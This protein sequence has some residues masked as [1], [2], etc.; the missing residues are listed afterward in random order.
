[1]NQD[2][3]GRPRLAA[4]VD[5]RVAGLWQAFMLRGV[6]A[7]V[8]GLCALI[9]PSVSLAILL[10]LVGLYCVADGAAGVLGAWRAAERGAN[11][12]QAL[13]GIVAGA[14]L[15]FW[16]GG[17]LRTLLV[18]F[19]AWALLT[20]LSQIVAARQAEVE[21]SDRRLMTSIGG[22]AAALGPD[23]DRLARHRGGDRLGDR[24]CGAAAGGAPDLPRAAPQAPA[25]PRG[26]LRP[27]APLARTRAAPG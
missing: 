20:G 7:A 27:A 19:G 21:S 11:L 10:R 15:L 22:I 5:G 4:A 24:A 1:M 6:L 3:S 14:L 16:P 12:L 8:L 18:L 13:L 9:W 25:D 23:P 26:D 2:P 17:S